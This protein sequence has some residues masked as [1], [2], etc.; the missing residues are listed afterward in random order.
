[1]TSSRKRKQ[2]ESSS[3][4]T[5][6]RSWYSGHMARTEES[7]TVFFFT[8]SSRRYG[9]RANKL[10]QVRHPQ[11]EK[12]NKIRHSKIQ[13]YSTHFESYRTRYTT[14][15]DLRYTLF[16]LFFLKNRVRLP[17][18]LNYH[19]QCASSTAIY[20]NWYMLRSSAAPM[21]R[22]C[23]NVVQ[24]IRKKKIQIFEEK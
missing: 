2:D 6:M 24:S 10:R 11:K 14:A 15:L 4:D 18:I 23:K 13:V 1:M 9:A 8:A 22:V 7:F 21:S 20:K 12:G 19:R 16:C 3:S 17:T 5:K